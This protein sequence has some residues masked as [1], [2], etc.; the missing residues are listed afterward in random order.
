MVSALGKGHMLKKR[1]SRRSRMTYAQWRWTC[2][3][4]RPPPPVLSGFSGHLKGED[5]HSLLGFCSARWLASVDTEPRDTNQPLPR[6]A[7]G[8][9]V[10][11]RA[12]P[13]VLLPNFLHHSCKPEAWLTLVVGLQSAFPLTIVCTVHPTRRMGGLKSFHTHFSCLQ[14]EFPVSQFCFRHN[15]QLG[16]RVS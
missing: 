8:I 5:A 7:F 15:R 16:L 9:L 13:E 4:V 1:I 2:V 11:E 12:S 10:L 14:M 3:C 6:L